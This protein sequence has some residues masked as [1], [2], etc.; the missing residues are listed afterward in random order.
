MVVE[1]I[2][3]VVDETSFEFMSFHFF[4]VILTLEITRLSSTL[5][6]SSFEL[7]LVSVKI[8]L[9]SQSQTVVYRILFRITSAVI[10]SF[11]QKN[12]SQCIY[13]VSYFIQNPLRYLQMIYIS[14]KKNVS[15]KLK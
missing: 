5:E 11:F 13:F 6:T 8:Q 15:N 14:N 7:F 9:R 3:S 10:F 1:Y 4:S 2:F 12:R